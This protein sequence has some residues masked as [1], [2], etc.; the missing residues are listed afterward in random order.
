MPSEQSTIL[1]YML[2]KS[3]GSMDFV[4][5]AKNGDVCWGIRGVI[6]EA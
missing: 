3:A 5:L 2:R 6:F 1:P 4:L